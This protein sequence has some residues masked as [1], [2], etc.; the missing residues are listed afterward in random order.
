MQKGGDGAGAAP[1]YKQINGYIKDFL[2]FNNYN[3]TL[4][5]LE[6]EERTKVVTSKNK[7]INKVPE[8]GAHTDVTLQKSVDLD[9]YPRLYRFFEG[10]AEKSSREKRI[11]KSLNI[12]KAKH[13]STLQSARQI[14]SIAV[15]CLQHLH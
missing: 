10:D 12:L 2:K 7:P 4:E 13:N 3:S 1:D 11:E 14:F 8:V 5:C 6:A 15:N 9:D